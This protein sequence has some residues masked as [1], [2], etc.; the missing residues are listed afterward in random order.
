[1]SFS[2]VIVDD[3]WSARVGLAKT[4]ESRNIEVVGQT[5]T[6]LTGLE[7]IEEHQPSLLITEV[8]LL[9]I[10]GIQLL[11]RARKVDPNLKVVLFSETEQPSY[12]AR[13]AAHKA[14]DFIVK[15]HSLE[16]VVAKIEAV[17]ENPSIYMSDQMKMVRDKMRSEEP[18]SYTVELQLTK[19]EIQVLRHIAFGLSNKEIGL[20]LSISVETV[21]E[22]VQNI[23]RKAHANDRTQVAVNAVKRGIV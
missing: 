22:H 15:T 16:Q 3:H 21:K 14:N 19:R 2:T 17:L 7:L 13:A 20:S 1:M 9:K 12:L 5:S 10:D 8:R 4:L 23:L 6:A 11:E 18:H